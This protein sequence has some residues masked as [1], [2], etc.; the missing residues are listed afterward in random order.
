MRVLIAEDERITRRSLEHKLKQWGHDVVAVEDGAAAWAAFQRFGFDAVL[1]DWQM[2]GIDGLELIRRIRSAEASRYT[3]LILLTSKSEKS[4]LVEGLDAGADDFLSK[5]FDQGELQARLK[6]GE[7]VI[8]LE[9]ELA[10]RNAAMRADLDAAAHYVRSLIPP[11]VDSP[12]RIDWRYIPAGDLAGDSLGYHWI[13]RE[14]LAFYVLDVTGHGLDAALLSVTILNV[15]RSMSLPGVDFCDP[16]QVLSA[17]NQRF[18]ME[19]HQDR[20]F[21]AWYGVL[22]VATG[23]LAWCGGG[24]PAAMVFEPD[25]TEPRALASSGPMIGMWPVWD[26]ASARIM[27]PRGATL[28]VVSDGAFEVETPGGQQGTWEEFVATAVAAH[29]TKRPLLD[30][31]VEAARARRLS[32]AFEDDVTLMTISVP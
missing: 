2:P 3:Y 24:H 23:E 16:A 6:A 7:R 12:V 17:L 20:C 27:L 25:S 4:D 18:P 15:L 10:S 11:P 22:N 19:E 29:S 8:A 28:L 14:R 32:G 9:R 26:G 31:L 21:T 5:P 13:D 1:S 30:A